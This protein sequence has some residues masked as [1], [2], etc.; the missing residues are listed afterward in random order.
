MFSLLYYPVILAQG[1]PIVKS[2]FLIIFGDFTDFSRCFGISFHKAGN[3]PSGA[4]ATSVP[5]P[6]RKEDSTRTF[7]PYILA[8]STDRS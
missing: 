6:G 7:T 8:S 3:H 5:S 1:C 4:S 2:F